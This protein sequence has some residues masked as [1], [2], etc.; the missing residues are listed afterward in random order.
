MN[1]ISTAAGKQIATTKLLRMC[2]QEQQD[3]DCGDDDLV[4]QSVSQRRHRFVDQTAAVID[5]MNLD[6]FER[7]CD[8]G[9]LVLNAINHDAGVFAV[10]HHDHAAHRF[11]TVVV[12][13]TA[14]EVGT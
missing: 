3:D 13:G 6:A 11:G 4:A 1:D 10:P 2:K 9:N 5:A 7:R 8:R 14:S 12:Q